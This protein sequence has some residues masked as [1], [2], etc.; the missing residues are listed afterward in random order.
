[1]SSN[2][3][4]LLLKIKQYQENITITEKTIKEFHN[5]N[6]NNL[7]LNKNYLKKNT[8]PDITV[9]L[10]I[11]N[12]SHCLHKALR[13]IQNQSIKNLE[14]II[15]D[16][17]SID[18]SIELI[19]NYQKQDNRI[20]LIKHEINLGKIKSRTDGIKIATGKYITFLDGDDA[21]IHKDILLH[22]LYIANLGDF[23]IVEFKMKIYKKGKC[24]NWHNRYSMKTNDIVY[25][26]ELRTKFILFSEN[27]KYRAL[28]NRNLCGKIIKNKVLKKAVN[29]IGT[30]FTEDYILIYE[31]T[32]MIVSLFQIAKSYYYM[33]E[34]GYYYSKD[35][36]R[37][38]KFNNTKKIKSNKNVIKDMDQVKYLQFLIEKT[39]NNKIERKL[40]YYEMM[41]INNLTSFYKYINHDYKM[42][43]NIIDKMT[44]SRFLSKNQKTKLLFIKNKLKK[45]EK[46]KKK[47]I[48]V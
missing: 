38:I 11:F 1:M 12:Q 36:K 39:K 4:N 37:R 6:S 32:I 33:K 25:Q 21:F 29:N 15:I 47:L 5:I 23:D 9:I 40:I 8:F 14:I 19:K 48:H 45:K 26:P 18:N 13:S 43:Y 42:V 34:N 17:C 46:I 31:D 41:C 3:R 28:Q 2:R 20:I 35:D 24:I 22:S 10:I 30:K 16:D 27:P 44:K 7:L